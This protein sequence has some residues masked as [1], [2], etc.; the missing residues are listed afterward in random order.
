MGRKLTP[1]TSDISYSSLSD[2]IEVASRRVRSQTSEGYV[3]VSGEQVGGKPSARKS[4]E[5]FII[6]TVESAE[7]EAEIFAELE[8]TGREFT[9]TCS[10]RKEFVSSTNCQVK[11]KTNNRRWK[12]GVNER[13][14]TE[15]TVCLAKVLTTGEDLIKQNMGESRY[16]TR[17]M[18]LIKSATVKIGS[19]LRS[20]GKAPSKHQ[21]YRKKV[22]EKM[23]P[24][25]WYQEDGT[26]KMEPEKPKTKKYERGWYQKNREDGTREVGT[27]EDGTRED[28]TREDG[29]REVGTRDDSRLLLDI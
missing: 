24:G 3:E 23:V 27:R 7:Q 16:S 5:A 17:S 14:V 13:G 4:K 9:N 2:D 10:R 26:R 15:N 22:P 28:D 6:A 12:N 21:G 25:R 29:T 18:V 8:L 11:F 19:N 20:G 1:E